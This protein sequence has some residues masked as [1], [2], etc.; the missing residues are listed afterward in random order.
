MLFK[1]LDFDDS[2]A[3]LKSHSSD[4]FNLKLKVCCIQFIGLTDCHH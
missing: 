2:K 3:K 1:K 4:L